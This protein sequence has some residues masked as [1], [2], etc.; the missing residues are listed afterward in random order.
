MTARQTPEEIQAVLTAAVESWKTTRAA[1]CVELREQFP[2]MPVAVDVGA[3]V[4]ALRD[5]VFLAD[6]RA[7]HGEEGADER[8]AALWAVRRAIG[9][10]RRAPGPR[11]TGRL[12]AALREAET[13]VA[14]VREASPPRLPGRPRAR[15]RH[16]VYPRLRALG[17]TEEL[18]EELLAE[19]GARGKTP[20]LGGK[21]KAGRR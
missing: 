15:G 18:T 8:D 19:I 5:G 12:E 4:D 17:L 13:W 11:L 14:V 16:E 1:L 7:W 6:P 20:V 9:R 2:D 3:V 21:H 10:L